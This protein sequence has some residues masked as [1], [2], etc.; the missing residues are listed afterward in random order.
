MM[1][2]ISVQIV[3]LLSEMTLGSTTL[4]CRLPE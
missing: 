2:M 4:G 1:S 3:G